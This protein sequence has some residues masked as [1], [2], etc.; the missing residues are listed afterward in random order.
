MQAP[1]KTDMVREAMAGRGWMTTDE[2]YEAM[3]GDSFAERRT[4]KDILGNLK[5]NGHADGRWDPGSGASYRLN[6]KGREA[7]GRKCPVTRGMAEMAGLLRLPRTFDHL[8]QDFPDEPRARLEAM[9]LTLEAAGLAM[10]VQTD[11]GEAYQG[12]GVPV[13]VVKT[14]LPGMVFA[15]AEMGPMTCPEIM[16]ATG[17]S[18]RI[19]HTYMQR[20]LKA[21]RASMSTVQRG[22]SRY[23]VYEIKAE[24]LRGWRI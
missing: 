2:V 11:V 8:S 3:G 23:N 7:I 17:M 20:L 10:R 15:V 9:L 21:G 5:F 14:C 16:E 13:D 12:T 18:K 4:I 24:D 6:D 19:I 22:R 1:T